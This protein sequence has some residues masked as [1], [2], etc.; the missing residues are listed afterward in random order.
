VTD[1]VE[2]LRW[3]LRH[4]DTLDTANAERSLA[5]DEIVRLRALI[6][7]WAEAF[8]VNADSFGGLVRYEK[9]RDALRKEANR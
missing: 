4:T 9:A 8:G 6:T 1:I 7:E 3:P 5:A 2:R